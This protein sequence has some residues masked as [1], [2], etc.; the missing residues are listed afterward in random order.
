MK[1][2]S[3]RPNNN[4]PRTKIQIVIMK[5]IKRLGKLM[6]P[7]PKKPYRKASIMDAIGFKINTHFQRS[8]TC[9]TGYTM[10]VAYIHN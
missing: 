2:F 6:E 8:G 7:A 1:V 5:L 10:G 3:V 9:D 4:K